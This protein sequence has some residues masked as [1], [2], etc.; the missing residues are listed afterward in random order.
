MSDP[1][2]ITEHEKQ[3]VEVANST[4]KPPVV[5]V[6]GLWRLPSNA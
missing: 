6:H 1:K 5:F 3:Q 2:T 4:G